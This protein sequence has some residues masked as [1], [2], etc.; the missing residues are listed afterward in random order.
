MSSRTLARRGASEVAFRPPANEASPREL[1]LRQ[2]GS[3]R[4]SLYSLIRKLR[5][6]LYAE[7]FHPVETPH[8]PAT[9]IKSG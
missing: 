4:A 2:L 7:G 9:N 8:F 1:I 6:D 3:L 5:L